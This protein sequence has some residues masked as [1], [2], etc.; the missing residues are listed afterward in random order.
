[1]VYF[2]QMI[3]YVQSRSYSFSQGRILTFMI[4]YFLWTYTMPAN[5]SEL[6][7]LN[8][9]KGFSWIL[10]A[11]VTPYYCTRR[12]EN[13]LLNRFERSIISCIILWAGDLRVHSELI[14]HIKL[15][16]F[17][18]LF[19]V[20]R[21]DLSSGKH[22][23]IRSKIGKL[24]AMGIKL[25]HEFVGSRNFFEIFSIFVWNGIRPNRRYLTQTWNRHT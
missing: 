13:P 5:L 12:P 9:S 6:F 17:V 22:N 14:D 20:D 19:D 15:V 2:Q 21:M 23:K 25:S 4:V 24:F 8:L 16:N 7:L 18:T 10:P 11:Y 1:M 3:V